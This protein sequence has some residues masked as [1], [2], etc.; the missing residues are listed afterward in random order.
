M[1]T[2]RSNIAIILLR[3]RGS[4]P[5]RNDYVLHQNIFLTCADK[6][7]NY[8]ELN[9][10]ETQFSVTTEPQEDNLPWFGIAAVT[11]DYEIV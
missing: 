7:K 11:G 8:S 9:S 6:D 10:I 3:S 1:E 4:A 2:T 5:S